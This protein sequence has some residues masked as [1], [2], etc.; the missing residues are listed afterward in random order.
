MCVTL[1]RPTK[2]TCERCGRTERWD[3]TGSTWRIDATG[4]TGSVYCVHEWDINGTFVPFE[5]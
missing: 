3:E 1:R 5:E 4:E 2:R